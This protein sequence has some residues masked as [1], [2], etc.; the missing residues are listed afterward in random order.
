M[1]TDS[2]LRQVVLKNLDL[3]KDEWSC[4]KI[5]FWPAPSYDLYIQEIGDKVTF[6]TESSTIHDKYFF[7]FKGIAY[8]VFEYGMPWY[9]SNDRSV[10]TVDPQIEMGFTAA[11]MREGFPHYQHGFCENSVLYGKF[12]RV[13][14]YPCYSVVDGWT[15]RIIEKEI[16]IDCGKFLGGER[17]VFAKQPCTL[18]KRKPKVSYV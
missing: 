3:R 11:D 1:I 5:L 7:V 12:H 6:F 15:G 4:D 2:E 8:M 10:Y 18:R 9:P 13:V 17:T 14:M 16:C